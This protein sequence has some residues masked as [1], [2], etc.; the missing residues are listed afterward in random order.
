MSTRPDPEKSGAVEVAIRERPRLRVVLNLR[1]RGRLAYFHGRG[2]CSNLGGGE[3]T[4]STW[5]QQHNKPERILRKMLKP[6]PKNAMMAFEKICCSKSASYSI[7]DFIKWTGTN[8]SF[9]AVEVEQGCTTV[10]IFKRGIQNRM[11]T[12]QFNTPE[13]YE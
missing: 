3:Q 2:L 10:D 11:P 5:D 13:Y 8:S 4:G 7:T 6:S 9:L 1:L 12:G